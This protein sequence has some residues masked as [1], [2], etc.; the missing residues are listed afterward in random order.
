MVRSMFVAAAHLCRLGPEVPGHTFPQ[1]A[2]AGIWRRRTRATM[3]W[4][5]A[6][7]TLFGSRQ[8]RHCRQRVRYPRE[9]PDRPEQKHRKQR[10]FAG[11]AIAT[12]L[13]IPPESFA[14]CLQPHQSCLNRSHGDA[15][16]C[17]ST[18][19][20]RR[21]HLGQL[22]YHDE[23]LMKY[24]GE[25]AR[26]ILRRGFNG[27]Q[28]KNGHPKLFRCIG[29]LGRVEYSDA[30]VSW[31]QNHNRAENQDCGRGQRASTAV[32]IPP[33]GRNTPFT[34]A[35]TGSVAFTTSSRTWFTMFS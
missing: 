1:A 8:P 30:R 6:L 2:N 14:D 28:R 5:G 17:L 12:V 10:G 24:K 25:P 26:S 34:T 22:P 19:W 15:P 32:P 3:L 33:L 31:Q 11:T 16:S 23:A 27:S 4:R 13:D 21:Q 18:C 35:H 20:S 9:V 7:R 29:R